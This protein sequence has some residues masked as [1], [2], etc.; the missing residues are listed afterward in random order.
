MRL[1]S[2][3]AT[4]DAQGVA[5]LTVGPQTGRVRLT[6]TRAGSVRAFPVTVTVR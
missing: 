4:T 1:G 6:A 3:T 5:V 2:A